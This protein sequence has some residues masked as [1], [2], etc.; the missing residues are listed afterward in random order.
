MDCPVQLHKPR[1]SR[2]GSRTQ[3][4]QGKLVKQMRTYVSQSATEAQPGD[5]QTGGCFGVGRQ[6]AGS[7]GKA[8][9]GWLKVL[10]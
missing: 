9:Q 4:A 1:V 7:A 8:L 5:A 10:N 2:W 6:E 3:R